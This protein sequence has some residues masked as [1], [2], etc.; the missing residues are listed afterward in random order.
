MLLD[1]Q[2]RGSRV[3]D[4][5]L[6]QCKQALEDERSEAEAHLVDHQQTRPRCEPSGDREHL[7]LATRQQTGLALRER[8][9]LG[10]DLE[11]LCRGIATTA[12]AETDVL[13]HAEIEEQRSIF[14]NEDTPKRATALCV[15]RFDLTAAH[16]DLAAE[17]RE[18]TACGEQRRGLAGA[19]RAQQSDDFPLRDMQR[20]A[21]HDRELSVTGDQVANGEQ[22][23]RRAPP[24]G[25]TP[26]GSSPRYER[27]T[28]GLPR[29]SAGV[30]DAM[31]RPASSTCT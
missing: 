28:S 14:R 15:H 23:A 18:E 8:G 12:G 7:L 10:E 1:D 21:A 22:L 26:T 19:V 17:R 6:E 29:I 31:R 24:E 16:P 30:P 20:H 27:N 11:H 2:Q 13:L 5:L 9:E 25:S 4:H 3:G